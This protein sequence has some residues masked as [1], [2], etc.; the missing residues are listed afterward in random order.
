MTI[1]GKRVNEDVGEGKIP[2]DILAIV[3]DEI[4]KTGISEHILI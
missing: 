1:S 3:H 2:E 4:G